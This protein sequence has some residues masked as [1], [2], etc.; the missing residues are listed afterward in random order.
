MMETTQF[1]WHLSDMKRH[2]DGEIVFEVKCI[3]MAR[4]GDFGASKTIYVRLNPPDPELLIPYDELTKEIVLEWV[5]AKM[6]EDDML[7]EVENELRE[8][9]E[10]SLQTATGLPWAA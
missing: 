6:N 8:K 3:V 7:A 9:L 4:L 1:K 10:G 5:K 2:N